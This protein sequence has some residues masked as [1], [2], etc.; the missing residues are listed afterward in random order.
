MLLGGGGMSRVVGGGTPGT[1]YVRYVDDK[2]VATKVVDATVNK[3][4]GVSVTTMREIRM[5]AKL[6]HP[7][8][9]S[10]I[11]VEHNGG[12]VNIHMEF[13]PMS[14]RDLM[15][16][17]IVLEVACRYIR[18][19]LIGVSFCHSIGVLHRDIK[20]EN[21][22]IGCNGDLKLA[23][24]G[25]ARDELRL[26]DN[27][28]E[29][30]TPRMVTLWYRS[31]ELLLGQH[32]SFGA[33]VWSV[34]CIVWEMLVGKPLFPGSS[35]LD[36]IKRVEAVVSYRHGIGAP[37]LEPLTHADAVDFITGCL[38][39]ETK[40]VSAKSALQHHPLLRLVGR[41]GSTDRSAGE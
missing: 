11:G 30:Y 19:M 29:C 17:A 20:P 35:E 16:G 34:G 26:P 14:L 39:E 22:L 21:L 23:D 32:Y 37:R 2:Y 12:N 27:S 18:H 9:V 8:I 4:E 25:L 7:H 3:N 28:I 10:M 36:M 41:N 5:L 15:R 31:R 13:Y 24:F 40:R 6:K 33:D 1:V 38:H